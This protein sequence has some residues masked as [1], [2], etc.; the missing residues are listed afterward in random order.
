[1]SIFEEYGVFKYGIYANIFAEKN[2]SSFCICESYSHFFSK[3]TCEFDIVLTRT[4]KILTINELIKL[5]CFEQLGPVVLL[6]MYYC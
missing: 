3:N 5:T 1:M 4:V 6:L 2:V